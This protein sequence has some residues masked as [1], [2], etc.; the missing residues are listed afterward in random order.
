MVNLHESCWTIA[1]ALDIVAAHAADYIS[2]YVTKAAGLYPART[3]AK[4]AEH[5][6]IRCNVMSAVSTSRGGTLG[7]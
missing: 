4:I 3:I 6:G 7:R 2:I 5:A 1:D